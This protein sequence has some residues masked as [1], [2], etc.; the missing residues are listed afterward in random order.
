MSQGKEVAESLLDL[1]VT[2]AA[3]SIWRKHKDDKEAVAHSL[4]KLGFRIGVA[5]MERL[6]KDKPIMALQGERPTD[7]IKLLCRDFW[8]L[9][10]KKITD[11]LRMNK[12][13]IYI[14][15]DKDFK[16]LRHITH[17]V[18]EEYPLGSKVTIT[19]EGQ[20]V[21]AGT[22]GTI[23]SYSAGHNTV[24]VECENQIVSVSTN[25]I[26]TDYPARINPKTL[27]H[28]PS[29]MLRGALFAVDVPVTVEATILNPPSVEF[30][31]AT[32]DLQPECA[33]GSVR[34]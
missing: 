10:F 16:W 27:L 32:R 11:R 23:I 34:H 20:G 18:E 30:T 21:P 17:K 1:L 14:V 24:E 28:I 6:M 2:E 7:A 9:A 25:N 12:Q 33:E 4:E 19:G 29:G 26:M 8:G 31:I 3:Y 15:L 22:K 5:M 13:G